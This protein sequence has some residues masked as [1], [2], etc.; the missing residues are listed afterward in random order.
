MITD[1]IQKLVD[2][3]NLSE[4]EAR[5]AMEELMA[6]RATDA[7]V[8]GFLTSLRMKGETASEL[9][10]FARVMRERAEPFWPGE[11]VAV[12]DT[13]GTGGDRS[14]TFNISTAAAFVVAGAGIKVAKHGNRSATSK[15]GS[16]DV[17]EA[18]GIDIQMPADRLRQAITEIGIGFLFA[19]RYHSSIKHVMPARSQLAFRTV[20]NVIGPLS[21][22]ALPRY[23][24][25]GVFSMMVIDLVARALQDLGTEHALVIH[26]N[27]GVDEISISAPSTIRELKNG[28][29]RS[30]T[31][32]P[33][34]F[35]MFSVAV[36]KIRGGDAATNAAI[37]ESIFRGEGG[38]KRDVVLLNA[39]AAIVAAG[40]T[41]SLAEGIRVS[42]QSIDS[43]AAL[44]K[45]Q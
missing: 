26:G 11:P 15:C 17:M 28:E 32:C 27:D 38:P 37:I 31:V 44:K 7:Q 42:E 43:G 24:V 39:G 34:D 5:H 14:G 21:N 3:D 2:R 45:L 33:E 18:L 13:C 40:M 16:A 23:Q 25:V 9:A 8:A 10:T 6:G 12:L 20:F 36:E 41:E 35:G 4:I 30:Y 29:I 22:P 19:P 1:I